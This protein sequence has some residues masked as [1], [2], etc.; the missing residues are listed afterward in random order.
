[1]NIVKKLLLIVMV[2]FAS[3]IVFVYCVY[4]FGL[5]LYKDDIPAS[6]TLY[7]DDIKEVLWASLDGSQRLEQSKL[8][9]LKYLFGIFEYTK[10]EDLKNN[11]LF[12]ASTKLNS[13][14]V[15][16]LLLD[17]DSE[18]IRKNWTVTSTALTIRLSEEFTLEESIA[19]YLDS[20]FFGRTITGLD[21]AV[22]FYYKKDWTELNTDEM[23][24]LF[25][26]LHSPSIY[27]SQ[28]NPVYQRRHHARAHLIVK[29]LK[30]NWPDK[31]AKYEYQA[32]DMKPNNFPRCNSEDS[33][34]IDK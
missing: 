22:S 1:V 14:I 11:D 26:K 4:F 24:A 7:S 10:N 6:R 9:P 23:I 19:T 28:C 5:S 16:N 3:L 27:K 25:V 21:E 18:K 29:T 8:S 31:Y 33:A 32:P 30:E 34:S 12:N 15:R 20:A 13:Q 2:G 17:D